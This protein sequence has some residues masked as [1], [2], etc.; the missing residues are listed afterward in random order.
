MS[1]SF[2]NLQKTIVDGQIVYAWSSAQNWTN[3]VP[4]DD[5]IV[6]S[7]NTGY[8]NILNLT[9]SQL[10]LGADDVFVARDLTVDT[11]N[12]AGMAAIGAFTLF[13]G[14]PATLTIN[15]ITG[16]ASGGA[17]GALGSGAV[18]ID[19]A[20]TDLGAE[21]TAG[22]DG[23]VLLKATPSASSVFASGKD[24][25]FAFENPGADV[26]SEM[27]YD[28][29]L[30]GNALE[31]PG[32]SVS[33]VVYGANS[34]AITTNLGTTT[35]SNVQFD[36][37][38]TIAYGFTA[39]ADKTT[40]LEK[41]TILSAPTTVFQQMQTST[42]NNNTVYAWST[43]QNW[44]NG[45]PTAN[46]GVTT[47]GSSY[48]DISS[49][50]LSQLNLSGA[51]DFIAGN[52]TVNTLDITSPSILGAFTL[53]SGV[54]ATLTIN[55]I[56]GIASGAFIE[57]EGTGAETIDNAATDP[58]AFYQVGDDGLLLMKAT[59][60]AASTF[61]YSS[62]SEGVYA[63][64]N[65][66]GNVAASIQNLGV[67][68]SIELPGSSVISSAIGASSLAFTTN[69]G[70]T[71]FNNVMY[72]GG[73][74]AGYTVAPDPT[75]G[76]LK[77]TFESFPVIS[78]ASAVSA[79]GDDIDAGKT[80]IFT[81]QTSAPVTVATSGAL[82]SL[83]LNDG[84]TAVYSGPK[85]SATQ[86]LQF[87]YTV[88][89]GDNVADLKATAFNALPVGVTIEDA[90]GAPLDLAS[91]A[92]VDTGVTVD[93]KAPA[94][95]AGLADAGIVGGFVNKAHD[96]SAQTLKGSA[97]AKAT[98]AIFDNG[99][100]LGTT[101][102][103]STGAWNFTLGVLADGA[104]SLTAKATDGAGNVSG[105]SS[106]LAFTVDTAA[107]AAPSGLADAGIVGGFVNK[108]HD[109]SAQSLT[110]SAEANAT[111][112]VF[113]KGTRL[114]TTTA[115]GS[116]GWSFTL[117][118]LADGAHILRA[119][120]T[121]KAGNV[122]A[123]SA[124]LAFTV[125]TVAPRPT[126]ASAALVNAA[127]ALKGTATAN[128][129]ITV[130]DGST[131][132][133]A[134]TASAAGAWTFQTK[135]NDSAV[136]N[137]TATA[138]DAHGNISAASGALIEGSPG[139]D[140]FHFGSGAGLLSL[141]GLFGDGG[142]DTVDL[143]AAATLTDA[144][145]AHMHGV[146]T[147]ELSG[148]SSATLGADASAAGV[149]VVNAGAGATSITDTLATALTV[150]A[151]ALGGTLTLAGKAIFTVA[152]LTHNLA[153]GAATGKLTVTATGASPQTIVLGSNADALTAAHGGDV[154]T[155]GGGADQFNVVGHNAA[156]RFVYAAVSDS[157]DE[158][159]AFDIITGFVDTAN[160][161]T[162]NDVMDFS[163]IAGITK[164][165]GALAGPSAQVAAH[166]VAYFYN[167]GLN[168]TLV[169]ANASATTQ[170][171][172]SRA[173]MEIELAGGDFKL[174]ASDFKLA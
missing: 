134:T 108:A 52:L 117:G 126:I 78:G 113:D 63:F 156:D 171:Q 31:V 79:S 129:K 56:A 167:A 123:P 9:L 40:G 66:G 151:A 153:A 161:A 55:S 8:D 91:F 154:I 4:T 144:D 172:T 62:L 86:S 69:L 143:T 20:A 164:F 75:T 82:P 87:S 30:G 6:N 132:L 148:A 21:Y 50:T 169:F 170:A 70:K 72:F 95:P 131:T 76:L 38:N 111:V 37:A 121:D 110:G 139:N 7:T 71:S 43:S 99:K 104:H 64:D 84:K 162:F 51:D 124:A 146:H 26:T 165:Q 155:G 137:F 35:F 103:N 174:A 33:S 14:S 128:A 152:G 158:P 83:Q 48:D 116:G 115:N 29:T 18:T 67:D 107:P 77:I 68:D 65:P 85:N 42:V 41:V 92:T 89:A 141:A 157:L 60:N 81:L 73:T 145:F 1:T 105:P 49:L 119:T 25:T 160:V 15:A 166:S 74:P 114:G 12:I 142:T 10:I 5:D 97:E 39:A 46:G 125:D 27:L 159:G 3:G 32:S 109:T 127:W 173:L 17:I 94:A 149:A 34:I 88:S 13:S 80:V 118:V 130:F 90:A 163:A 53:F 23:L 16:I 98:V 136:R 96:T 120:A 135:E 24:G 106:A 28:D 140:T 150:G 168:E 101:T 133:G 36:V 58:G 102:A 2:E 147:L 54:P 22:D 19:N 57:A 112:A 45:V 122:S 138:T 100:Q 61:F 11:L 59:P 47:S 44:T 93:T